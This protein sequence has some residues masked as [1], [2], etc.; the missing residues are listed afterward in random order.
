[1]LAVTPSKELPDFGDQVL[2]LMAT[3]TFGLVCAIILNGAT[4]TAHRGVPL[5]RQWHIHVHCVV[6]YNGYFV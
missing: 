1:M 4:Y 6:N 3:Y 5:T 2:L